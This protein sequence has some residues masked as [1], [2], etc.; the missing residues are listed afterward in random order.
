GWRQHLLAVTDPLGQCLADRGKRQEHRSAAAEYEDDREDV[1]HRPPPESGSMVV[2]RGR[3]LECFSQK[4]KGRAFR[5]RP[6]GQ[7]FRLRGR[8]LSW[9]SRSLARRRPVGV[10]AN[11]P[12]AVSR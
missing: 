1:L 9:T 2:L 6:S 11:P 5:A 12:P 10:A 8:G 4:Q 7:D 3:K